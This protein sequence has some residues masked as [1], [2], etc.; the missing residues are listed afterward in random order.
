M[1]NEPGP[2]DRLKWSWAGFGLHGRTERVIWWAGFKAWVLWPAVFFV[3]AGLFWYFVPGFFLHP[4]ALA[5]QHTSAVLDCSANEIR[6]ILRIQA[7][8]KIAE[9]L[10]FDPPRTGTADTTESGYVLAFTMDPLGYKLLFRI[11][12][13]TWAGTRQ[14]IDAEGKTVSGHGGFDTILCKPF[15]GKAL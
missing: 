1:T 2:V 7:D 13:L 10:S 9:D 3:V 4:P 12:R 8:A 6:H 11:N 5:T 14:L 15:T